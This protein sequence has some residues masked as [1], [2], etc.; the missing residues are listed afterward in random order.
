MLDTSLAGNKLARGNIKK[1]NSAYSLTEV[2][3]SQKVILLAREYII[4]HCH[5]RGNKFGDATFHQFLRQFGVLKLIADGHSFSCSYQSWQICVQCMIWK[6]R[7]L[8]LSGSSGTIV[9]AGKRDTQNTG[10][11]YSIFSV[12]LVEVT[13]PEQKHTIGV[14]GLQVIKLLHHRGKDFL[15]HT[16]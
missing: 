8:Q 14:L 12:S 2:H 9:S 1:G 7:H 16:E 3:G 10:C 6:A 11:Y 13:A 4:L 15:C 5:T